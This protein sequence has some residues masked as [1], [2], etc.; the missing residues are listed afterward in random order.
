MQLVRAAT[1]ALALLVAGCGGDGHK[2]RVVRVPSAAMSPTYRT[3]QVV[4][5]DL[6]AYRSERPRRGDVV[7]FHP[8]K[9]SDPSVDRCAT[10]PQPANGHPCDRPLGGPIYPT[11]YIKRVSAVGGD[12]LEI[13]NGL[14]YLSRTA[15]G[16]F[17]LQ[18]EPNVKGG[19]AL[20]SLCNLRKPSKVPPGSYFMTGDNRDV[21]NDS[22]HWGPVPFEWIEGK[23]GR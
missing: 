23:V 6:D 3:G 17:K 13:R 15:H 5:V 7:L 20:C 18:D 10:V 14:V 2:T 9:G 21:S 8:P 1:V 12:W 11:V 4:T 22:R 16:P 19:S